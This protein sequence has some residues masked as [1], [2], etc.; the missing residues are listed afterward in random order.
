MIKSNSVLQSSLQN[1]Y[2][3]R[4]TSSTCGLS[5]QRRF[6]HW[7]TSSMNWPLAHPRGRVHPPGTLPYQQR[8]N[9]PIFLEQSK[10][11][12]LLRSDSGVAISPSILHVSLEKDISSYQLTLGY[13]AQFCKL[14]LEAEISRNL[15]DTWV[16]F[17]YAL[18]GSNCPRTALF[19]AKHTPRSRSNNY[20]F[21]F[22][23]TIISTG[24]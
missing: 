8:K 5:N 18:P 21:F 7:L 15:Q 3:T 22:P 20:L 19:H 2:P 12:Y 13:M 17:F 9:E 24:N 11:S 4:S 6:P 14:L 1:N 16:S 23:Q 10:S